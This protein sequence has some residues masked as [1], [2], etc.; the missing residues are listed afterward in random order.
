VNG[1]PEKILLAT[2]GLG[3]T[4]LASRAAVDLAKAGGAELHLVHVWHTVPSPHYD[5]II[6]SGLEDPGVRRSTSR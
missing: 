3:T 2:H 1:F 6:R 4:T 5:R